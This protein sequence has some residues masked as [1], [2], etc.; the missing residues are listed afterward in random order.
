LLFG[1]LGELL[2]KVLLIGCVIGAV[3]GGGLFLIFH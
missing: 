3:V 2:F 1:W